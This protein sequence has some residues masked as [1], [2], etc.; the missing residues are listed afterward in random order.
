MKN[1]FTKEEAEQFKE[2]TH[3]WVIDTMLDGSLRPFCTKINLHSYPIN[4]VEQVEIYA[5]DEFGTFFPS[6][7]FLTE[8][9]CL[10]AAWTLNHQ[11]YVKATNTYDKNKEG[12]LSK[13]IENKTPKTL[14]ELCGASPDSFEKYL[15]E[16]EELTRKEDERIETAIGAK[17]N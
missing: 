14:T 13:M 2:F 6:E 11:N 4:G 8:G 10:A 7:V 5:E 17:T 16:Q 1:N 15:R 9:D 3:V 12:I